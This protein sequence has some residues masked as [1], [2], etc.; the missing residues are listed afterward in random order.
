[1]ELKLIAASISQPLVK[2]FSATR[3]AGDRLD[4]A[5]KD[6]TRPETP[7]PREVPKRDVR[8]HLDPEDLRD[9][10]WVWRLGGL[11]VRELFSRVIFDSRVDRV[12]GSAAQLSFYFLLG[13]F[14][15]ML[16]TS[17]LAGLVL[18]DREE[19]TRSLLDQLSPTLPKAALELLQT[20]LTQ[21]ANGPHHFGVGLGLLF[22]LWSASYGMEAIINGM[23]V[24]FDVRDRRSWWRRRLIALALTL[25]TATAILLVLIPTMLGASLIGVVAGAMDVETAG[26]LWTLLKYGFMVT[27]LFVSVCTVYKFAPNLE[28]QPWVATLPGA[29][30]A[31]ALWIGAAV[32]FRF[33]VDRY[34]ESYEA[35]YGAARSRGGRFTLVVHHG[36]S[37]A[38]R[39]GSQFRGPVGCRERRI[40][41]SAQVAQDGRRA[42]RSQVSHSGKLLTV[43]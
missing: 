41:G 19:L 42:G 31:I 36:R 33:Y 28:Y 34:F 38:R 32:A 24:A 21:I 27:L 26:A 23:N 14:P 1:L 29:V 35:M 12:F 11:S 9:N 18:G 30:V 15:L 22:A 13:F 25:L 39:C 7:R 3:A 37:P 16:F 2:R 43:T 17:W 40:S 10:R 6:E 4:C 8:G 20:T 5:P